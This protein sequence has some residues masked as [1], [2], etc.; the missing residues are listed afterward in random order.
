MVNSHVGQKFKLVI[1]IGI[2]RCVAGQL[3]DRTG[4]PAG[5]FAG[6]AVG[7]AGHLTGSKGGH[8]GQFTGIAVGH[9]GHLTG[10]KGGHAGQ[11]TEGHC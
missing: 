3:T 8:A 9:A 6:I 10:S 4:G 2:K 5:Q 1:N 7:H 11:S